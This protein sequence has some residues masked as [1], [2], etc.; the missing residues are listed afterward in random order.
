MAIFSA[1]TDH[2][3]HHRGIAR[4]LPGP[5]LIGRRRSRHIAF[6]STSSNGHARGVS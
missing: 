3:A 6:T 5:I 2:A 1:L 4:A